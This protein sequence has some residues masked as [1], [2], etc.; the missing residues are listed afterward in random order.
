VLQVN[1]FGCYH[2]AKIL[3]PSMLRR[4]CGHL[5]FISSLV[6]VSPMAGYSAYAASKFAVR[7]LADALRSEVQGSKVTLSL[8]YPPDTATPG[9]DKENL[10]KAETTKAIAS[11]LQDKVFTAD[12]VAASLFRG[13]RRGM[14]HLPCPDFLAQLG[15][16]LAAV[17][18]PRPHWALVEVLMAPLLVII[19]IVYRRQQDAIVRMCR[20]KSA[21]AA[22]A[23]K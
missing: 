3:L 14:Y 8:G 2:A 1:Y 19:G 5:C 13:L 22:V 6:V 20:K 15:L 23:K 7:G 10:C 21:A 4:N 16:S 12:V 11:V 9:F 18:T 17:A